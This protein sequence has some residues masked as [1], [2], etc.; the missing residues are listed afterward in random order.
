MEQYGDNT[1]AA[2]KQQANNTLSPRPR[3]R[4]R[5]GLDA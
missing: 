1:L 2:R 3:L 5:S 4:L